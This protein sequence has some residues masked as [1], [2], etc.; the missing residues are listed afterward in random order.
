MKRILGAESVSQ[1]GKQVTLAGWASNIRDHGGLIFI[2]MRD[3]SGITQLVINPEKK[4]AFKVAEKIGQEFVIKATGTVR[5]RSKDQINPNIPTGTIE[6]EVEEL[7]IVNKSKP[8]PFPLDDDGRDIDENL[9]LTYRYI[10]IRRKRLKEHMQN[11]HKL[12]LYTRNWFSEHDFTEIQTPL[13]TVSSPEGARDFLVPSR[14]YPGTFYALP[15]A[16]QQYKQLLMVGG[17]NKYFQIAPCFRDE[18][19]RADRHSGAF[20][21]IDVEMSFIEEPEELFEQVEPFFKEAAE[22]LSDKKIQQYP[23]PRIT[24]SDAMSFYGTDKPDLRFGMK[25]TEITEEFKSSAMEIFK[26]A[27]YVTGVL[28]DQEFSRKETDE[29]IEKAKQQ[30]AKGMIAIDLEDGKLAGSFAKHFDEKT[31]E[32]LVGKFKTNEY[33]IKGKQTLFA[34]SD[35]KVKAQKLAGWLRV[36]MGKL[37][38]LRDPK[39]LAYAWVIDF[40]MYEWD[41]KE[42]K[43]DFGHNPFSMPKGGLEALKSKKP[44]EIFAQQYDMV[45]NGYEAASGSI[46]NHH[47]ETLIEAFKVTGY[48]EEETRKKFGH[49]ISAF[50]YGAPPH[51]GFA[52]G[53]DRMMMILFD[54]ENIREIYAFP[55]TNARELMM[56]APREVDQRDID[57]LGIELKDKGRQVFGQIKSMLDEASVNYE[58]V[59]HEEV[60][61]S[62]QAAAIRGESLSNGAKAL[63]LK[64]RDYPHKYIMTVVPADR[65]VDLKKVSKLL[66]EEFFV[67]PEQEVEQWTGIKVGG[68][69]PFGRLIGMADVYFDKAFWEKDQIAFNAGLRTHSV[70]MPA[71]DLI[72]LAEPN[73]KIVETISE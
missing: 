32:A 22:A 43:W 7:E 2:D 41:E 5:E 17:V 26:K 70:H 21:Q 62:E 46:R 64:S 66:D 42:N 69:P 35:E 59:E 10:D 18:D 60:R 8:L 27:E 33:E 63:V 58:V 37:L 53:I 30:G 28:V 15:Q 52:P 73:K 36:E 47:P 68:V 12:I 61:T 34:F 31:Q 3:W 48:T 6:I 38:N 45:C 23:F 13:L 39:V 29:W 19:P 55:M 54:E 72:K 14:L 71:K 25:L 56:D 50:E 24:H 67:A 9:R 4:A 44:E 65:K 20:Y 49:M 11:R 16:P 57:I 40:P 1:I 51:G